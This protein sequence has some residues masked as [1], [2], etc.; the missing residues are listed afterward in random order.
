MIVFLRNRLFLVPLS[1]FLLTLSFFLITRFY[2]PFSLA[3]LHYSNETYGTSF[4]YP[5]TY[6]C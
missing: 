1:L 2:N 5:D 3:T 6:G 4:N